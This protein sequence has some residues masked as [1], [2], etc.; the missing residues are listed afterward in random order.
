M[1]AGS[2]GGSPVPAAHERTAAA[3]G[4]VRS[5]A[6]IEVL[7]PIQHRYREIR[8]DDA[9]LIHHLRQAADRLAPIANDT[10]QRVQQAVGLR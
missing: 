9:A 7:T 5:D 6:V 2:F 3:V 4:T 1:N 8:S 10:L